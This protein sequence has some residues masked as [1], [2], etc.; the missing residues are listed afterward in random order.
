[1][2]RTRHLTA[3]VLGLLV[4]APASA[5]DAAPPTELPLLPVPATPTPAPPQP[6]PRGPAAEYDPGYLYLPERA[7]DVAKLP[8]C[9]CRPLGRWWVSPSLELGWSEGPRLPALVRVGRTGPVVYGGRQ[10]ASQFREGLGLNLGTWLDEC[11]TRGVDASFYYL[12]PADHAAQFVSAFAPLSLPTAEGLFPL[13]DPDAGYVGAYQAGVTTHYVT[14]D[15]NYRRTLYCETDTRLDAL[16]GYRYAHL[17]DRLDLYGKR[18]GPGGEIVRFRDQVEAANDF[19]GGQVGLAGEYRSGDW[20]VGGTGTVAFGTVFTETDLRGQFRVNGTVIPS[21]FYA[22]PGVA[23]V[24]E[25]SRFAVMPVVKLSVGRQLGEH[26]R[27]FV[28]YQ[29]QYLNNL[30]RGGDVLDPTPSVLATD[31]L[32]LVQPPLPRRDATT[33]DLWVQSVNLGLELRY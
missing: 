27:V 25:Q 2:M 14:A 7:P 9:P 22:R 15:V 31:P 4:A 21:G 28:G 17:G 20:Y 33:S 8:P 6:G 11:Q 10:L 12:S 13:T 29:F 32:Q 1:M 19:H 3:C 18:L 23:G 26:A 24:R 5:R 16:V 30:T